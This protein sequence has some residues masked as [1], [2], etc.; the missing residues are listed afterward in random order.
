VGVISFAC[1]GL[2]V[3]DRSSAPV[4]KSDT[5]RYDT[6]AGISQ[7]AL[8]DHD[9]PDPGLRGMHLQHIQQPLRRGWDRDRRFLAGSRG[10]LTGMLEGRVCRSRCGVPWVGTGRMR[11]GC[12]RWEC[13]WDGP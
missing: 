10:L 5:A 9:S 2:R 1:P 7:D 12:G 13:G 8:R 4:T 11:L 3:G 6:S